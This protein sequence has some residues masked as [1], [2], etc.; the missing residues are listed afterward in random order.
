MGPISTV[1][2]QNIP[3]KKQT[4]KEIHNKSL[5]T[6]YA[7]KMITLELQQKGLSSHPSSAGAIQIILTLKTERIYSWILRVH[8]HLVL[9]LGHGHAHK[10][11]LWCRWTFA[12]ASG[13]VLS[14]EQKKRNPKLSESQKDMMAPKD[15]TPQNRSGLG[16]YRSR[17]LHQWGTSG[18]EKVDTH[19]LKWYHCMAHAGGRTGS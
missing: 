3:N 8:Y 13:V 9:Y 1:V 19:H 17:T 6:I 2:L 16:R 4:W 10:V 18:D 11:W 14:S 5:P 12:H 7:I 15:Q